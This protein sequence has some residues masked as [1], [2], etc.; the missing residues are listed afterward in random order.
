[1]NYI[2]SFVDTPWWLQ[3]SEQRE[4]QRRREEQAR[5]NAATGVAV[6]A[7]GAVCLG[8]YVGY[9]IA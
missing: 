7:V 1:M 2:D 5:A 8:G 9:K 3:S 6:V 4:R